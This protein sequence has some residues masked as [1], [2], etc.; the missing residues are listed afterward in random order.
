[1]IISIR[2]TSG[3]GKTTLM[4][5]VKDWWSKDWK[6]EKFENGKILGYTSRNVFLCGP[7]PDGLQSGGVDSVKWGP[8]REREY[9]MNYFRQWADKGYHLI[10][11]GLME[12]AEVNRTVVWSKTYPVHAIFLGTT[13]DECLIRINKRR[14]VRGVMEPVNPFQTQRK[15]E[16]LERVQRRLVAAGIDAPILD[17][18]AAFQRIQELLNRGA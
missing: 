16:E 2:G 10:S 8:F 4:R 18:E 13:L 3:C 11:E 7:Y 14:K 5:K 12:S 1:M 9:R 17:E 6:E 15:F